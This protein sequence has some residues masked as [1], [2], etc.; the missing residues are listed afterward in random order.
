MDF[1]CIMCLR[2]VVYSIENRGPKTDPCGTPYETGSCDEPRSS[3]ETAKVRED[4]YEDIK[5]KMQFF[6][7]NLYY[8]YSYMVGNTR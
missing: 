2:G 6:S 5:A 4:I 1:D 8:Y 3:M 7:S